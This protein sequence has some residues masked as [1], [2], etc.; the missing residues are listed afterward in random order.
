MWLGMAFRVSRPN[1][2]KKQVSSPA[3]VRRKPNTDP[4]TRG[5][6][7]NGVDNKVLN[8]PSEGRIRVSDEQQSN[9]LCPQLSGFRASSNFRRGF[10]LHHIFAPSDL[11]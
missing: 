10:L 6:C 5:S 4:G 2:A 8:L 9:Y 3:G 11:F 7:A 1:C